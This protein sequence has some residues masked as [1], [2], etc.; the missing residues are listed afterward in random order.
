MALNLL[1]DEREK[2]KQ[3]GA[4]PPKSAEVLRGKIR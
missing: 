4:G 2:E 1:V 3:E